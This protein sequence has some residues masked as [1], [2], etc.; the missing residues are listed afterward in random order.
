MQK[1]ISIV[2]SL[3]LLASSA[4]V[5]YA[6]HFCGDVEVLSVLTVGETYLSCSEKESIDTCNDKEPKKNSCCKT[7]YD[8]VEIDDN[9]DSATAFT[10]VDIPVAK[11]Y[12][13]PSNYSFITLEDKSFAIYA[14]YD[15]PPI[16][17]DFSA[18]YQVYLI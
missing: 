6:K 8:Q 2:L 12:I 7:K 1:F 17:K 15:P 18:L 3:L 5:T 16:D 11:D 4:N 10:L 13:S 14:Y 9:F